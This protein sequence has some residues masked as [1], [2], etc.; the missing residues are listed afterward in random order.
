MRLSLKVG[1]KFGVNYTLI[2]SVI[3]F[4]LVQNEVLVHKSLPV[5][6]VA[7]TEGFLPL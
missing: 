7:E 1:E 2:G 3:F 6:N 4:I 5:S